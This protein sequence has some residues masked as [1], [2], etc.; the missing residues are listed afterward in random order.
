MLM[1]REKGAKPTKLTKTIPELCVITSKKAKYRDP[2]TGLP[3]AN[4]YAY[5]KIQEAKQGKFKWS[6]MLGCYVGAEG[7]QAKGVPE[8]FFAPPPQEEP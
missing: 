7:V 8:G 3:Y 1:P 5:K 2:Q 4:V 6:N